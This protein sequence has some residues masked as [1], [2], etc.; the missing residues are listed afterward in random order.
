MD[1]IRE[2]FCQNLRRWFEEHYAGDRTQLAAELGVSYEQ[3]CNILNGRRCGDEA[4]RRRTAA[5]VGIA[6]EQMIGIIEPADSGGNESENAPSRSAELLPGWLRQ[7]LPRLRY[8]DP[9]QRDKLSAWL[10]LEGIGPPSRGRMSPAG[11]QGGNRAGREKNPRQT[12]EQ[13][14]VHCLEAFRHQFPRL[15][16]TRAAVAVHDGQ[17]ILAANAA[18][19]ALI[20]APAKEIIGTPLLDWLHVGDHEAVTL[21]ISRRDTAPCEFKLQ[22][23]S[24]ATVPVKVTMVRLA[25]WRGHQV[26][27]VSMRQCGGEL[28]RHGGLMEADAFNSAGSGGAG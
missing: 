3:I 16:N 11:N 15:P 18:M 20:G 7:I 28:W 26:R 9:P 5:Y 24:G 1:S 23:R 4:W 13:A 10:E 14:R 12:T 19:C 25:K 8:L 2:T 27:V 6:Y 21:R 22:N 17:V